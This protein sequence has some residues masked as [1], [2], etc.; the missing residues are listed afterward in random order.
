MHP[1]AVANGGRGEESKIPPQIR[2]PDASLLTILTREGWPVSV[3]TCD[4]LAGLCCFK[5]DG[6]AHVGNKA[7]ELTIN[8]VWNPELNLETQSSIIKAMIDETSATRRHS[9]GRVGALRACVCNNVKA[10]AAD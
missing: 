5:Q 3:G 6:N 8:S 1:P 9:A 7:V 4:L 2:V 10:P